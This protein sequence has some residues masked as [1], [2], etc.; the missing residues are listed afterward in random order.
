MHATIGRGNQSEG[1]KSNAEVTVLQDKDLEALP[2]GIEAA[3][4]SGVFLN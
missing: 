3:D 2:I 4:D 1:G